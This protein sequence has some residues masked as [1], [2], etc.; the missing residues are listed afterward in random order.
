MNNG[1]LTNQNELI[2]EKSPDEGK[3]TN[4]N[5]AITSLIKSLSLLRNSP[6][7]TKFVKEIIGPER[8]RKQEQLNLSKDPID[9]YRIQGF[10]EALKWVVN[11][12]K[13]EKNYKSKLERNY[14]ERKE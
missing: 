6:N 10:I 13:F 4:Q 11:I 1:Q 14:G 3:V 2:V 7:F 5:S 9:M 12:E 8:A